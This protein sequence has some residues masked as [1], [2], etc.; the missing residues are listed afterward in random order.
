MKQEMARQYSSVQ[1]DLRFLNQ[2]GYFKILM[3]VLL[4]IVTPNNTLNNTKMNL[5]TLLGRVLYGALAT[6]VSFLQWF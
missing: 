4:K 1:E 2:R 3:K 5:K 6:N